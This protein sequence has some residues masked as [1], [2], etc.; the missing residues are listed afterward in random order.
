MSTALLLIDLQRDFLADDGRLPVHRAQIAPMLAAIER[1]TAQARARGDLIVHVVNAFPRRS[2]GNLF[3]KFA[4]IEGSSGAGLD[5]RA[6]QPREGEP[7]VRK[8]AG[9]A[10]RQTALD[11]LLRERGVHE[12]VLTGVFAGACVAATARGARQRGYQVHIVADA[13]ADRSETARAA[14]LRKLTSAGCVISDLSSLEIPDL[15]RQPRMTA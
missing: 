4:A 13:V 15:A 9:D 6:P 5:P 10:F 1:V 11:S 8:A 12:L 2:I 3:R 7:T 14:A